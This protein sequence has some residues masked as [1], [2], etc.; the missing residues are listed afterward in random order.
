MIAPMSP[1]V[2]NEDGM[3]GEDR[4]GLGKQPGNEWE[5]RADKADRV[6]PGSL[7]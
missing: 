4:E 7:P 5:R 2:G 3:P 1:A 6:R